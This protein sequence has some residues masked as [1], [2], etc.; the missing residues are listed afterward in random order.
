MTCVQVWIL[1]FYGI[2]D[3][4]TIVSG[5]SHG[6][7]GKSCSFFF[8]FRVPRCCTLCR[9]CVTCTLLTACVYWADIVK[10]SLTIQRELV[11]VLAHFLVTVHKSVA[12]VVMSSCRPGMWQFYFHRNSTV[13]YLVHWWFYYFFFYYNL[14][15][16]FYCKVICTLSSAAHLFSD[17]DFLKSWR[18]ATK[19]NK[20]S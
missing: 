4:M 12:H 19:T 17:C 20:S 6:L 1:Y 13:Y 15:E 11:T 9:I 2:V 7:L 3:F 5:V 18:E 8:L 16:W 14:S 10:C